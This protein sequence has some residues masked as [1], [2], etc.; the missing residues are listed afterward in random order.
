MKTFIATLLAAVTSAEQLMTT[1]DYDFMR[2][3]TQHGKFYDTVEQFNMRKELFSESDAFVKMANSR[4]TKYVAGHNKFSD[5]TQEEKD[6][7]V[8]LKGVPK[9]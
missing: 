1:L 4:G 2:Y 7:L 5:W 6:A 8:G 3:V 9:P